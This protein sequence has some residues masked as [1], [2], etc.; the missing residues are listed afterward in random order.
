M[1]DWKII[2]VTTGAVFVAWAHWG[3]A[4]PVRIV[5]ELVESEVIS[6][7]CALLMEFFFVLLL[8][9]TVAVIYVDPQTPE[10]AFAAG[11]ASA[12]VAAKL[13]ERYIEVQQ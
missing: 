4:Q 1:Y 6:R 12:S 9:V 13:K 11:L 8:N 10:Q 7:P 2:M 5:N 3:P